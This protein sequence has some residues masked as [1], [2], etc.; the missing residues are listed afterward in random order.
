MTWHMVHRHLTSCVHS[1]PITS[2]T[3]IERISGP[4]WGVWVFEFFALK[5]AVPAP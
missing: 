2:Y 3:P 4:H 5:I 1:A